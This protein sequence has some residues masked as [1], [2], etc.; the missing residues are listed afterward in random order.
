MRNIILFIFILIIF[1]CEAQEDD[2]IIKEIAKLRIST[3]QSFFDRFNYENCAEIEEYLLINYQ[4]K[5][6]RLLS[7]KSLFNNED[8]TKISLKTKF[9]LDLTD[10][11]NPQKLDFYSNDWI[12]EAKCKFNYQGKIIDIL[13]YFKNLSNE[14]SSKWVIDH[15]DLNA[16]NIEYTNN[17]SLFL[18]PVSNETYFIDI[19]EAFSNDK[20]LLN[21]FKEE[22]NYDPLSAFLYELRNKRIKFIKIESMIY[23]FYQIKNWYFEVSYFPRKSNNSGWL[24]S[25]L[26]YTKAND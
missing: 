11:L 26:I 3:I 13:I 21:Y 12:I 16:F 23:K 19:E 6:N 4:T 20:I 10:S 18:N 24:I 5:F 25:K 15:I 14:F 22:I 17:T 9:I 8:T 2:A 7:L 1:N